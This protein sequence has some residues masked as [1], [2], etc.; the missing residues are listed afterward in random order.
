MHGN[1]DGQPKRKVNEADADSDKQKS[2]FR[3]A[4]E[5]ERWNQQDSEVGQECAKQEWKSQP[6]VS[7]NLKIENHGRSKNDQ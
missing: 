6:E 5:N 1:R 3:G 4:S 2:R 7:C